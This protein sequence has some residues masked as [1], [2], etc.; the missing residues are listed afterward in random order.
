MNLSILRQLS[1]GIVVIILMISGIGSIGVYADTE[2]LPA[3]VAHGGWELNLTKKEIKEELKYQK[4]LV[5]ELKGADGNEERAIQNYLVNT[6]NSIAEELGDDAT[7]ESP[8]FLNTYAINDEVQITISD[9]DVT[10]DITEISDEKVATPEEEELLNGEK[11]SL[12]FFSSIRSLGSDLFFGKT[13]YAAAS[14]TVS[15]RHT[16][17][18]YAKVSGNRLFTASIGAKFTYNGKKSLPELRKTILR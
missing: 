2:V 1:I 5:A 9:T 12:G 7:R 11:E 16:R 18:A 14:K 13:A 15:G 10:L 4:E 17:T 3:S 8:E 6:P